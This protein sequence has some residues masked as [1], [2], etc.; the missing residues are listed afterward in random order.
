MSRCSNVS[1]NKQLLFKDILTSHREYLS[2]STSKT[3]CRCHPKEHT[4]R[5]FRRLQGPGNG[6]SPWH[7]P[8]GHRQNYIEHST[9]HPRYHQDERQE[10]QVLM[11]VFLFYY[12]CVSYLIDKG[13]RGGCFCLLQ[14]L[15]YVSKHFDLF[16]ILLFMFLSTE[17]YHFLNSTQN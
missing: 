9:A 10:N 15:N 12:D 2:H 1:C 14:L 5:N 11:W 13:E 3:P 7:T 4:L 16:N 17:Y 6:Y 8:G